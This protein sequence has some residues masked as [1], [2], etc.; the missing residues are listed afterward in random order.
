MCRFLAGDVLQKMGGA[1]SIAAELAANALDAYREEVKLLGEH[2]L[3]QAY[4]GA[5]HEKRWD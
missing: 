1:L 5:K 3:L 2:C 4:A